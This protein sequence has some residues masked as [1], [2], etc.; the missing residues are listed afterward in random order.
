MHIRTSTV[1]TVVPVAFLAMA[2]GFVR[3]AGSKP[4]QAAPIP[5]VDPKFIDPA[6]SR[7]SIAEFLRKGGDA[8]DYDCY[9]CHERNKPLKLRFDADNNVIVPKEH[10]DIV[11]GHGGHKRNNNCFNCHDET[12]L[13]LLQTRD[14]RQLK[15]ADSTPL[16]G[17]CHGPT[18]RDWEAGVHGRTSG[19]WNPK[20]ADRSRLGCTSCHNPH[21]PPFPS[22]QPAP[23]PHLLHPVGSVESRDGALESWSVGV[24]GIGIP[25]NPITPL[26]H[27]SITPLLHHSA[28]PINSTN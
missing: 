28:G 21:A 23:G 24:L 26:L 20:A 9:V 11:M 19:S 4:A 12:N 18:Y 8:S 2:V 16:C 17:S 3:N 22:R 27:C 5:L 10:N 14:G 1:L 25:E 15:L 13:E 7:V 6:P